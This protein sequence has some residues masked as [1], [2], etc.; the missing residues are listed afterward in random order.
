MTAR[1]LLLGL[2]VVCSSDAGIGDCVPFLCGGKQRAERERLEREEQA[3]LERREKAKEERKER[4]RAKREEKRK[5]Q[6]RLR[7]KEKREEKAKEEREEKEWKERS[8]R[9]QV[10]DYDEMIARAKIERAE[11]GGREEIECLK[12]WCVLHS[13]EERNPDDEIFYYTAMHEAVCKDSM[14]LMEGLFDAGCPLNWR[15]EGVKTPMHEA[16][17]HKRL[18]AIAFLVK[19][20]VSAAPANALLAD[21][22]VRDRM[23]KKLEPDQLTPE[24]FRDRIVLLARYDADLNAEIQENDYSSSSTTRTLLGLCDSLNLPDHAQALLDSGADPDRLGYRCIFGRG[25]RVWDG[26]TRSYSPQTEVVREAQRAKK[27]AEKEAQRAQLREQARS[28]SELNRG[29]V[30]VEASCP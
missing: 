21:S 23:M 9:L 16:V 25:L 13:Q 17:K 19:H 28:L 20:G 8:E 27:I 30:C 14:P 29:V 6:A 24:Q 3:R 10:G 26:Y 11:Q 22:K 12:R 15:V 4:A 5:E 2:F 7:R 1:Y 18:P